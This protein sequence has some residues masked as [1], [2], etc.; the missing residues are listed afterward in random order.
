MKL[1]NTRD[2]INSTDFRYEGRE[3]V[4]TDTLEKKKEQRQSIIDSKKPGDES[5]P[6]SKKMMSAGWTDLMLK[7]AASIASKVK[8]DAILVNMETSADIIPFLKAEGKK[9]KVIVVTKNEL[10]LEKVTDLKCNT[11]KLPDVYLTRDGYLKFSFLAGISKGILFKDDILVCVGG[12]I[13]KGYMDTI[14]ILK[15]GDESEI[16]SF[17]EESPFP[18]N[19]KP[20]IFE[21]L[22]TLLMEMAYEGREGRPIGTTFVLGDHE[23]VLQYSHQLVFNPFQGHPED[24]LHI[25]KP[26]VRETV[27]EFSSIDGAFI[28]RD[29]GVV[30]AAGRYLNAAHHGEPMPQGLGAR[31]SSAAA[32]TGVTD[33]VALVISESTGKVTIFRGGSIV[34]TIEKTT[35]PTQKPVPI[36]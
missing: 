9:F 10:S 31:H 28:I 19:I 11:I 20:D 23:K 13:E 25:T 1:T 14:M 2:P 33:S 24:I 17:A 34:T 18:K 6:N 32:I 12:Q 4:E 22:L 7:Q 35:S 5:D 3:I 30:L 36:I 16:V 15:V 26:E 21:S 27:K 8:A 29:D